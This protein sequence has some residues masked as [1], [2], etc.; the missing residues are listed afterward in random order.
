MT[1][2]I[3]MIK[4]LLRILCIAL[5]FFLNICS[6]S[7]AEAFRI[8]DQGTA[9]SGQGTAFAAQADDASAVFYNPAGMTQLRGIQLSTGILAVGGHVA[10][11]NAS[12]QQ[13]RGNFDGTMV[14]PAPFHFYL[15]GHL[16]DLGVQW[17]D[18]LT[19]GIGL[20]TPFGLLINY[21]Q[22]APFS[23]VLTRAALPLLDIKPTVAFNLNQYIALGVGLDIYTF[24]SFAGEGGVE[25]QRIAGAPFAGIGITPGSR[26]EF[27]GKD[28][29]VG[30][31]VSMLFTPSR[32]FVPG[33][34]HLPVYS[35][36]CS[37]MIS[38][39]WA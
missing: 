25:G 11:E 13:V 33:L 19:L 39:V 24:A 15:T 37:S 38:L 7:H 35:A 12:G 21:P 29:G 1:V 2:G 3:H 10:F 26:L 14:D 23:T 31:N 5:G 36:T 20:N 30:F 17:I 27:N 9:A 34:M 18:G 28:T 4:H 6:I 16:P 8:L 32:C 22:D